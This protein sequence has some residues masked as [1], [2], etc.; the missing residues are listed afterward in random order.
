MNEDEW[1]HNF[2]DRCY[3]EYSIAD[4]TAQPTPKVTATIPSTSTRPKLLAPTEAETILR[5][6]LLVARAAQ[7][8]SLNWW[9]DRSL[10][11]EGSYVA[12]RLFWMRPRLAAAKIAMVSGQ[13]RLWDAVQHTPDTVHL[14]DLGE[15]IEHELRLF[16]L[17]EAMIPAAPFTS[18]AQLRT[19]IGRL[20]G[21]QVG[22]QVLRRD[23][24]RAIEIRA[25][26]EQVVR[27]L[28]LW[29]CACA[30]AFCEGDIGQPVF[31]YLHRTN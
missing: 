21:D 6:R 9:N 30:L 18:V 26:S 10:T 12:E 7:P 27:L 14:F 16:P 22:Y 25:V 11:P 13:A 8:D 1:F 17:G 31:P 28:V 4:F 5:L 19:D 3:T 29:A 15:M 2:H 23:E 20:I 24:S